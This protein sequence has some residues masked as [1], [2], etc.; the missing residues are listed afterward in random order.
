MTSCSDSATTGWTTGCVGAAQVA[1]A[2]ASTRLEPQPAHGRPS[3]TVAHAT[4]ARAAAGHVPG[5][6]LLPRHGRIRRPRARARR[7]RR[8]RAG[9]PDLL[10]SAGLQR[11]LRR[12]AR[13][14]ARHTID[15]LGASDEPVVVPSGSCGDMVIHQYAALLG[16]DPEY[17][18]KARALAARTYE[19]T[20][21]LRA[22]SG[23]TDVGAHG[24]RHAVL[25]RLLP[26][27]ARPRRRR[28][29]EG[30]AGAGHAARRRV[31]CPKPRSAAASAACSR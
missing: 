13:A 10:R 24:D 27:P 29:A 15:V 28:R 16:D 5:R 8:D 2:R 9:R 7:R 12:R 3:Y 30:A 4:R 25:P 19:L 31:R 23:V 21:F 6:S 14:L 26:R 17:G 18:P 20:T 11:R 22:C 1:D